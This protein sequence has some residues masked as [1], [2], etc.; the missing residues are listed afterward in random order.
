MA[1][2]KT[3]IDL[4]NII[5]GINS[6]GSG[7][8]NFKHNQEAL[9]ELQ[10]ISEKLKPHVESYNE[11]MDEIK[12][13]NAF[14]DED[15]CVVNDEKGGY[16]FSKENI[17]KMNKEIKELL[18]STFEIDLSNVSAEHLGAYRFLDGWVEGLTVAQEE[19]VE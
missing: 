16:K 3:Y 4:V 17:K 11:R 14:T 18:E 5:N 1:T 9:K 15:N 10:K 8:D 6:I 19:V 2:T 7:I 12:L 13:D